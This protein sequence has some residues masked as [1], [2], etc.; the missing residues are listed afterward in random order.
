MF[1]YL[2]TIKIPLDPNL[3]EIGGLE[4]TWHGLF[5]ALGVVVGVLVAA[6]F[7]RRAGYPEDTIYNIAL[8]LII[9]GIIG[10][11]GLYVIEN[12]GSFEDDL[13][14]IFSINAGGISIYGAL[15]GGIMGATLYA[16][17]RKVPDKWKVAD[18]AGMGAILGMAV[19]RVGDVINGEHLSEATSLPW[20]VRYTDAQSPGLVLNPFGPD[21]AVHPAVAYELLADLAVFLALLFVYR[22]SLRPG[23]TFLAWVFLYGA[24]RLPLSF[25]RLDDIVWAG[26]RTAQIIAIVAMVLAL[27]GAIYLLVSPTPTGPTRAERRRLARSERRRH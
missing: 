10:A 7:A 6:F 12:W 23:L 15:I 22:H 17:W 3:F 20:G 11:R 16:F 14:D 19:G 1:S 21:V 2:L 9:G 27:A 5:S 13:G 8:A 4:V 25:L 18:I 26:L 24:L